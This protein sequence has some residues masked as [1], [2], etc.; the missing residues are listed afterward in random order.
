MLATGDQKKDASQ[1]IQVLEGAWELRDG[2]YPW[3]SPKDLEG[4]EGHGACGREDW[5]ILARG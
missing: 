3:C 2:V 1:W 4:W 5:G